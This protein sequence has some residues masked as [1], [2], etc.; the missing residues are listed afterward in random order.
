MIQKKK[1]KLKIAVFSFSFEPMTLASNCGAV[2]P[3]TSTFV[4]PKKVLR[5]MEQSVHQER[6]EI[7]LNQLCIMMLFLYSAALWSKEGERKPQSWKW[8]QMAF[9]WTFLPPFLC[10]CLIFSGASRA[11]A[12][13]DPASSL[14]ATMGVGACGQSLA[15][16][17]EHVEVEFAP[18]ADSATTLRECCGDE[19]S[20]WRDQENALKQNHLLFQWPNS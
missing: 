17:P 5:W 15:L 7:S 19:D 3:T 10:I 6:W 18:A 8:F 14:R 2:T 9:A 13:G 12:S 16:A 1:L 4:K 11:I 20:E